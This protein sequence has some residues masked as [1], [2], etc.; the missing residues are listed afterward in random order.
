ME[1]NNQTANKKTK[2]EDPEALYTLGMA[3]LKGNETEYSQAFPFFLD[4]AEL[5]HTLSEYQVGLMLWTGFGHVEKDRTQAVI[6][7]MR[8]A[9]KEEPRALFRLGLLHEQGFEGILKDDLKAY[10]YYKRAA[11]L[12]HQSAIYKREYYDREAAIFE[13]KKNAGE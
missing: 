2:L 6:W 9:Q 11:E 12:G 4:A 1:D 5:G 8:A 10:A 3:R 7:I 13:A